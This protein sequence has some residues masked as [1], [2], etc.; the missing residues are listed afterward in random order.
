MGKKAKTIDEVPLEWCFG[1]GMVIDM[2][3][4]E[5]FDPISVEDLTAFLDKHKL[6][7]KPNTI[8]LIKTGRDRLMGTKAFFK[9]PHSP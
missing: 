9:W 8:V 2:A 7:I 6:K 4:K 1:E 3:H 5:D